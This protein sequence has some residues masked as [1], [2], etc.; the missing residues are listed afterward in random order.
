MTKPTQRANALPASDHNAGN[1]IMAHEILSAGRL[2]VL[3][4][5]V[6]ETGVFTWRVRRGPSAKIGAPAGYLHSSGYVYI[7]IGG[8]DYRAHRLAWL[9]VT[10]DWPAD[11]IDHING[12]RAD[13]RFANLR[14]LNQS[15]NM[16]NQRRPR[17]DNAS[18]FLG[19]CW[20][21]AHG[22]WRAQIHTNGKQCFI[23]HFDTAEAA[24]AAY[25]TA[26]REQHA[27]C[28]I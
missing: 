20:N 19:V 16:Q 11:Q 9:Y 24:H 13:N 12:T 28:T 3:L 1:R 5:Y 25:L 21:K 7:G 8:R 6:L 14:E 26:K 2:R 4:R 10:G 17:S 18:G 23:G 22:L 27:G 15:L